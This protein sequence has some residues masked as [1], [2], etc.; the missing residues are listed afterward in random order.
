M[1][2]HHYFYVEQTV[3]TGVVERHI[4]VLN[5]VHVIYL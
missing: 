3:D 2:E 4:G 5:A 1:I